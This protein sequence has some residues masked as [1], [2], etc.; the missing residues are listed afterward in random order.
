MNTTKDDMN[1]TCVLERSGHY[2]GGQIFQMCPCE[3]AA[4]VCVHCEN[5]FNNHGN[6]KLEPGHRSHKKMLSWEQRGGQEIE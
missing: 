2:D 1:Y 3:T 4:H 5:G 6:P